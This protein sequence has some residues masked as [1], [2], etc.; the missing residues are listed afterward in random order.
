MAEDG[1]RGL[2]VVVVGV[3]VLFA[4][5]AVAVGAQ[6][7]AAGCAGD[8]SSF[9]EKGLAGE[10]F[11]QV[12]ESMPFTVSKVARAEVAGSSDKGLLFK[13]EAQGVHVFV[14]VLGRPLQDAGEREAGFDGLGVLGFVYWVDLVGGCRCCRDGVKALSGAG[15]EAL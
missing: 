4:E 12:P 5:Q 8:G 7:A 15:G 9:V 14:Q 13:V 1:W 11:C 2:L 6:L 3:V 10:N